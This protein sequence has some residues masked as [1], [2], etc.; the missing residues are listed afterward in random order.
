MAWDCIQALKRY[1]GA[2]DNGGD[3]D[4]PGVKASG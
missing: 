4:E 3:L 1:T 2:A